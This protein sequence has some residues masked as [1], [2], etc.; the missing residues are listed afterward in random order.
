MSLKNMDLRTAR[1]LVALAEH[2]NFTRAADEVQLTQSALS[3]SI[4]QAEASLGVKLFDRDRTKVQ[5]TA[6]GRTVVDGAAQLLKQAREFDDVLDSLKNGAQASV[7]FGMARTAAAALLPQVLEVEMAACPGRQNKVVVRS[8]ESLMDVL[9]RREIEFFVSAEHGRA[10]SSIIHADGIANFPMAQL[11]RAGHPLLRMGEQ[12][13]QNEFPWMIASSDAPAPN[14]AD[15]G[16]PHLREAPEIVLEDLG[17]AARLTEKTDIIWVTSTFSAT[18]ELGDG[19]L[20]Q[21]PFPKHVRAGA[22]YQLMIYRLKDRTL[23]P[24][25]ERLCQLFTNLA[26][27]LQQ[28]F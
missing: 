18:R 2:L 28:G 17:C 25:A 20:R 12:S 8:F 26:L 23:S 15:M 11:V 27:R 4:R 16:Y 21:L 3:R 22:S 6:L 24:V 13:R 7:S 1:H 9:L 5:L 14:A 10:R 19:R